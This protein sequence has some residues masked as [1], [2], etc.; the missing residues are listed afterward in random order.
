MTTA[1]LKS[2]ILTNTDPL[3]SLA[4]KTTTGG[5]LNAFKALS[6]CAT[7]ATPDYSLSATPAS[8]SVVQGA[9]T[10][11]TVNVN[12]V[13]GFAGSVS[14]SVSGLPSGSAGTFNPNPATAASSTLSVTTSATTPT[15]SY[16]LTIT[17]V[18]GALTRT[19]T[20]TLVVTGPVTADFSLSASPTSRSI[21]RGAS[22]TYTVTIART[23]GFAGSVSL[24]AAG[25]PA[26]ATA[27]F[28]PNPAT[29]TSSTLTVRTTS[30]TA[31][32]TFAVTI[33]GTS[34]SLSRTASVTLVVTAGQCNGNCP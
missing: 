3:A 34:G 6:A 16:P 32:G 8:Q 14:L 24:T 1:Q 12:R 9:G 27:S 11:Y 20:A 10:S 30:T 13:G 33:T 28:S 15:G 23:G 18:S 2:T 17:G 7:P 31:T 22:T 21:A 29:A 26:G 19:T 25:L 4:G 5:R